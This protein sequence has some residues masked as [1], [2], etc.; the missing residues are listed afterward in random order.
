M[1]AKCSHLRGTQCAIRRVERSSTKSSTSQCR[2]NGGA[3]LHPTKPEARIMRPEER[4]S[5]GK[6]ETLDPVEYRDKLKKPATNP[7]I[8][9]EAKEAEKDPSSDKQQPH[10]KEWRD[11]EHKSTV[12]GQGGQT[13]KSI[14]RAVEDA[15]ETETG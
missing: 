3:A 9:P 1:V 4:T 13:A 10:D 7:V 6:N 2:A 11:H 5:P 12:K 8:K 14:D 15:K